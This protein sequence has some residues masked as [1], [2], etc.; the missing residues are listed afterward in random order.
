MLITHQPMWTTCNIT[1]TFMEMV[2]CVIH[3]SNL[4]SYYDLDPCYLE[5]YDCSAIIDSICVSGPPPT[6]YTCECPEDYT[7]DGNVCK[8]NTPKIF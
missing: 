3:C 7:L 1:L 5:T 6:N 8:S 2:C 4:S